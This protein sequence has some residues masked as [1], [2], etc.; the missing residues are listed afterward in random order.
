MSRAE[1]ANAMKEDCQKSKEPF[2]SKRPRLVFDINGHALSLRQTDE[3][4]RASLEFADIIHADG[5]FLVTASKWLTANPISERSTTTDLFHDFAQT[6]Q[7]HK[8]SFYLLGATEEV[9]SECAAVLKNLYPDL[10]IAGRRHGYF[11]EADEPQII[12][13]INKAAPDLLWVGLGKPN[14]QIFSVRNVNKINAG[15]IITCGGCFNYVTG[16]YPRAPKWLQNLNMEWL[17]RMF[18]NPRTL[19]WR[20][21]TTTP[22]ALYLVLSK[23]R[24]R[25]NG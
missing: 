21:L 13:E 23:T 11:T 16:H 22:H 7:Q 2:A 3:N 24:N 14:E 18:T 25:K 5:G 8:L 19:F 15:W 17:F 9:N 10:K 12:E 1:L 20:Y 4:Y 6:A